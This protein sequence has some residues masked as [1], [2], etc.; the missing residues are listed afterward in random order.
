MR[1]LKL[2][3]GSHSK[4]RYPRTNALKRTSFRPPS[5]PP[6]FDHWLANPL[7]VSASRFR[8]LRREMHT[9]PARVDYF[10]RDRAKLDKALAEELGIG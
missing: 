7:H 5:R 9:K 4:I 1:T 3:V 6:N 2:K 10:L 8:R